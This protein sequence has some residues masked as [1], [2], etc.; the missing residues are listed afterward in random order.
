MGVFLSFFFWGGGEGG[1]LLGVS[2]FVCFHVL[3]GPRNNAIAGL[4]STN[5]S[6]PLVVSNGSKAPVL[7]C[8][9][10]YG[11]GGHHCFSMI[12]E[13]KKESKLFTLSKLTLFTN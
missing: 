2:Q 5:L 4:S 3:V 10:S 6:T 1:A 9:G 11:I 13:R 8:F 12:K 7:V